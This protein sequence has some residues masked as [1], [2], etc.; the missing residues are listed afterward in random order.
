MKHVYKF[1][2]FESGARYRILFYVISLSQRL[3]SNNS[4]LSFL[5]LLP[6]NY[7]CKMK[8]SLDMILKKKAVECQYKN[9]NTSFYSALR[10]HPLE[11]GST[12]FLFRRTYN[13]QWNATR[14]RPSPNDNDVLN[15]NIRMFAQKPQSKKR[16]SWFWKKKELK[17]W[18]LKLTIESM[19]T[20]KNAFSIFK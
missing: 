3:D 20:S 8:Y 11:G 17:K 4:Y 19:Q 10:N 7:I 13:V 6:I 9:T 16:D 18:G 2:L 5:L 14:V 1:Y 15:S 12:H